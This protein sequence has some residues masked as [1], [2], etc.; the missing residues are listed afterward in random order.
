MPKLLVLLVLLPPALYALHRLAL[1]MEGRGWIYYKTSG[2]SSTKTN[3]FLSL[4][5]LIEPSK[6]YV[7]EERIHQEDDSVDAPSGAPPAPDSDE[8]TP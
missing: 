6:Q 7:V 2:S 8:K 5:A 4:Q 3:A 1:W